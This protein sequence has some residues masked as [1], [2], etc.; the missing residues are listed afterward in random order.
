MA[1]RLVDARLVPV[2]EGDGPVNT[3]MQVVAG[4]TLIFN[5]S[6]SIWAGVWFTGE[7]GPEGWSN[8]DNNPKFLLPGA[9]PYQLLG[10]LDN[11]YF[12][13]GRSLRLDETANQGLLRLEIND[14][15]HGNGTGAF[16]CTI[17]HYRN[18]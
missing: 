2:G 8:R 5:A 4:D 11:G 3:G 16:Q 7:N 18:D 12:E 6:G 10:L 17:Q 1:W 15:V 13:I 14:D 9:H